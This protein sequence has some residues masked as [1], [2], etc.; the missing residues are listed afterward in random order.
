MIHSW[1][2]IIEKRRQEEP[3]VGDS[4]AERMAEVRVYVIG[5]TYKIFL[6][7]ITFAHLSQFE[8]TQ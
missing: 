4:A 1:Q 5:T 6:S 8:M 7:D 3:K 2:R